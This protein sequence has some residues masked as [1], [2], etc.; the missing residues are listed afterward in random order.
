MSQV[1]FEK[2][3]SKKDTKRRLI[4]GG[5]TLFFFVLFIVFYS[6]REATK[7][8]IIHEGYLF[9]PSWEETNYNN[10]YVPFIVLGALGGVGSGCFL[11]SD[12][13][14]C[15]YETVEKDLH[16]IT[17]HRAMLYSIVYIDGKEVDRLGPVFV[18][19]V[20]ETRLP[21]NIRVTISFSRAVWYLAH[22]SFS[23]DTPS[24]EI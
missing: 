22:I 6:L 23:D 21:N 20:V 19:H 13:I 10:V 12:L 14:F 8:V 15:R 16:C 2:Q 18:S 1:E 7:E 9:F 24:I 17:I 3:L 5:L 11:L 4:E